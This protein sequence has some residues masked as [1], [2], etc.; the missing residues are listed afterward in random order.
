MKKICFVLALVLMLSSLGI[1]PVFAANTSCNI[2]LQTGVADFTI[3]NDDGSTRLSENGFDTNVTYKKTT[4]LTQTENVSAP[5]K[6]ASD[7]AHYVTGTSAVDDSSCWKYLYTPATAATPAE[8]N[9][10]AKNRAHYIISFDLFRTIDKPIGIRYILCPGY[11]VEFYFGNIDADMTTWKKNRIN[12]T[13]TNKWQN[14]VI[15]VEIQAPK[16]M[17]AK[18]YIDGIQQE[19][20]KSDGTAFQEYKSININ[21]SSADIE[22]VAIYKGTGLTTIFT[23]GTA[24]DFYFDNFK[25]VASDNAYVPDTPATIQGA[26]ENGFVSV[27]D[28]AL[29]S[30]ITATG[31][32]SIEVYRQNSASATGYD[33]VESTAALATNDI[34]KLT[35]Q[36]GV[37]SY[38]TVRK[39]FSIG[40]LTAPE[41]PVQGGKITSSLALAGETA[42]KNVTLILAL[43]KGITLCDMKTDEIKNGNAVSGNLSCTINVPDV[44][45]NYTAK[46]FVWSDKDT[47]IQYK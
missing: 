35:T 1:A 24:Y 33:L 5:H 43:Y 26:S 40:N 14:I 10:L 30:S 12:D 13:V 17:I 41:A 28:G 47:M 8:S 21:T 25:T 16:T 27:E 4:D 44:S 45:G 9:E 42:D 34:I 29:A 32:K 31:A 19:F 11:A 23:S 36:N 39:A 15:D 6:A 46:A 18:V 3:F 38:Y 7:V 22:T 20:L 37:Y 2:T